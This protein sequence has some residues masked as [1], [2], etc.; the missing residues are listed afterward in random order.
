MKAIKNEYLKKQKLDSITISD[1]RK[2]LRDQI[3]IDTSTLPNTPA[4]SETD[5]QVWRNSYA[6]IAG[7][8]ET[9]KSGCA[10]TTND[11]NLLR[12]WADSSCAQI[13]CE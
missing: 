8:Y 1:L 11:F 2:Q 5:T 3:G 7:Q 4:D 6:T 9:L 12:D 13:G 10:I